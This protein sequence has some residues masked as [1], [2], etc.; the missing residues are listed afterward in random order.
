VKIRDTFSSISRRAAEISGSWQAFTLA[1]TVI[2]CW[3]IGGI[4]FGFGTEL[5][6][7]L[8]NSFTTIVTFLMV[9]LIQSSQ[10]RETRALHLKLDDLI[11]SIRKANDKL[12]DIEDATDDEIAEAKDRIGSDK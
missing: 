8:I 2:I 7:L 9:F 4:F 3:F 10:N 11:L 1:F 12:I 5:Y 6:Q